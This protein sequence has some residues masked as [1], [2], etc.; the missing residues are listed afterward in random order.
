MSTSTT[1]QNL[2]HGPIRS[3]WGKTMVLDLTAPQGH[4][5]VERGSTMARGS[6]VVTTCARR[7]Q[8]LSKAGE[9]VHAIVVVGQ[10]QDP[11]VHPDLRIVTENLRALRDK[12]FSRA[13]LA[14]I[15]ATPQLEDWGMRSTLGM[16]DQLLYRFEYGTAKTY[17]AVTG[18]PQT[19]L[20]KITRHLSGFHHLVVQACFFRGSL[21]NSTESEVNNWIKKLRSVGPREVHILTPAGERRKKVKPITKARREK[22]AEE[23][24]EALGVE[25]SIHED[26]P[27][28][29]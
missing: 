20:S 18:H 12:W 5:V 2:L 26:E 13:K 22:I 6:V 14:I 4:L 15:T 10:D 3:R 17:A 21:D 7:L 19:Q 29:V 8:E 23:A 11:A 27:C 24:A 1:E 9:K 28:L 25:V 16:Y